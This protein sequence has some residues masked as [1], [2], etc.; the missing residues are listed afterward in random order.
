MCLGGE[1][2]ARDRAAV[3]AW[4]YVTIPAG[5]FHPVADGYD[6]NNNGN[7]IYLN[8]GSSAAFSAPVV[9]PGPGP[10]TVKK[11]ILYAYDNNSGANV[12]VTLYKTNPLTGGETNMAYA[13]SALNSSV[14]PRVFS[15]A[16]ITHAKIQRTQGAYLWISFGGSS[17][18]WVYAVKIAY[19]D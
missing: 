4:K 17:N 8:S 16:T 7:Y 2:G 11:V 12:D 5:W 3:N 1:A 13:Q 19:T 14:D 15:D 6:W 18:L 10:V 9:F